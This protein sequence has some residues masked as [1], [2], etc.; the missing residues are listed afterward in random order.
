MPM[1]DRWLES[2]Y[3]GIVFACMIL[4]HMDAVSVLMI[5]FHYLEVCY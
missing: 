4:M 5:W 1:L 3:I 2:L